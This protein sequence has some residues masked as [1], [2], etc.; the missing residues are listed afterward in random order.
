[1]QSQ[2]G[3]L[4]I[5]DLED[6][7]SDGKQEVEKLN[8]MK[9]KVE[10]ARVQKQYNKLQV[11]EEKRERLKNATAEFDKTSYIERLKHRNTQYLEGAKHTS[12]EFLN[13]D[14][15]GVVPYQ[16]NQLILVGGR[17]GKGKSTTCANLVYGAL[18][19]GKRVLV[20][21]NEE[22]AADVYNRVTCIIKNRSY[23]NHDEFSVEDRE[24]FNKYI[25]LL[26]DRLKVIDD[27]YTGT[28]SGMSVVETMKTFIE[29]EVEKGSND[30]IIIDY[31][32]KINISIDNDGL[33]PYQVQESFADFL[34]DII[35]KPN[36]PPIVLM[37]QLK[38]DDKEGRAIEDRV[39]GRKIIV[40]PATCILEASPDYQNRC[41][42][43][44]VHKTRF[45]EHNGNAIPVGFSKG[46]YVL[47]DDNFKNYV[48]QERIKEQDRS[49]LSN[50]KVGNDQTKP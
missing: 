13:Q 8:D 1:M 23:T 14:F 16:N 10:S 22:Q 37:V 39:E 30:V 41:T 15:K 36:C 32:Q 27:D 50:V 26:S 46:K 3:N 25:E 9:L 33:S 17:S 31:Y 12:M 40:K 35:K 7:I 19:K 4:W 29:Q 49:M 2:L 42:N 21:S 18:T 28:T 43:F 5:S 11:E 47:Y 48:R 38:P 20:L 6:Q 34:G 45:S 44:I 24:M